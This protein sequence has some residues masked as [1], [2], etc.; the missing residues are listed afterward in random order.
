MD[1]IGPMEQ[2][3][4]SESERLFLWRQKQTETEPM[5]LNFFFFN[6]TKTGP[7]LNLYV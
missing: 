6:E 3:E 5:V 7:Y 1:R 4:K 2:T